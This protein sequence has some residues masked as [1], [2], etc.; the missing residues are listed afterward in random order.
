MI[1]TD[2]M[3][4]KTLDVLESGRSYGGEDTQRFE[5]ELAERC[6][7]R[8]GVVAN[9]GTSVLLIALEALGVG[10]G[11]EVLMAANAYIGV[12]AAVVKTGATPVFV[13]ADA[14]TS[15]IAAD[16]AAA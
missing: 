7:R 12:L 13:E 4:R 2:D 3:R 9:S 16:A 10:P 6:G 14:A 8:Y 15:N 1:L 11:D 5:V